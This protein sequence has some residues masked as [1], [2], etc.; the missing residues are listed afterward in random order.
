[1]LGA[2]YT[3]CGVITQGYGGDCYENEE[4]TAECNSTINEWVTQFNVAY[5]DDGVEDNYVKCAETGLPEVRLGWGNHFCFLVKN[6]QRFLGDHI[7]EKF[8]FKI[9]V[10]YDFSLARYAGYRNYT[11]PLDTVL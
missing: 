6:N 1:M 2:V 10:D 3:V 4:E 8:M 5:S 7:S 11:S 9:P